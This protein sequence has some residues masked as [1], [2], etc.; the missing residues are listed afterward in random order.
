MPN[1]TSTTSSSA[2]AVAHDVSQVSASLPV[3]PM[4]ASKQPIPQVNAPGRGM[5]TC[6]PAPHVTPP[7]VPS[8]TYKQVLNCR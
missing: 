7:S 4:A 6:H 1:D 5:A 8:G 3:G 2:P